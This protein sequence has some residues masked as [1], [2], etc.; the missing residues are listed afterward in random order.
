MIHTNGYPKN[1][2]VRINEEIPDTIFNDNVFIHVFS[3]LAEDYNFYKSI[4]N[5][6]FS[7]LFIYLCFEGRIKLSRALAGLK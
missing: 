5:I 1:I 3:I 7:F 6:Y 2:P 4:I